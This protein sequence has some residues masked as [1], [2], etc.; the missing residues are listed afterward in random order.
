VSRNSCDTANVQPE[1]RMCWHTSNGSMSSGYRCGGQFP[2]A[3]TYEKI[4][5]QRS[6]PLQ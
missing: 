4:I 2:R 1:L 5:F 3:G 6:G